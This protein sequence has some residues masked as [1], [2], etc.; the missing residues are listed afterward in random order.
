MEEPIEGV[1]VNGEESNALA[2]R[3]TLP[4]AQQQ[5]APIDF[6][7]FQIWADSRQKALTYLMEMGIASTNP[8]DWSDQEGRPYPEQGACTSIINMVG[9]T[10]D[11][12]SKRKEQFEDENGP[13]YGYVYES[14][15]R[16]PQFGIG[17][18]PIVGICTSRD[19]FFS[20]RR[21]ELKKS[22][23][24]DPGDIMRKS[25]TN[26]RYRA[27]KAAVPQIA[28]MTWERLEQLTG[29]RVK[30]GE[31]KQVT[32]N[33]QKPEGAADC[34]ECKKAGRNGYLKPPQR[35]GQP[36]SCSLSRRVKQGDKYVTTGACTC[37]VWE[38]PAKPKAEKKDGGLLDGAREVKEEEVPFPDEQ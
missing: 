11:P 27:V 12:A 37:V 17:P 30:Q 9:I 26:L 20:K 7:R 4:Q 16:V 8:E 25:S 21:G 2:R 32:F 5:F 10:I 36:W 13:Y 1:L 38:D 35:A 24:I 14:N 23:E 31:T 19:A 33:S 6:Q 18:I 3:D 28:S 29:G 15:M 22:S 34:P